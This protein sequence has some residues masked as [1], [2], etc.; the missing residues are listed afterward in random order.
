MIALRYTFV[1]SPESFGDLN[2]LVPGLDDDYTEKDLES[3]R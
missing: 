1:P 3:F 2:L